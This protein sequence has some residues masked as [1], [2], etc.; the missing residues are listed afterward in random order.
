MET[1]K[2]SNEGQILIPKVLR[3]IC[4]ISPGAELMI[5]VIGSE[6]RLKPAQPLVAPTT[7]AA[8]RGLL[9]QPGRQPLTDA[10]IRQ[11]IAARLKAQDI[12]TPVCGGTK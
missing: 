5:S 6:I 7:V 4:Q 3:E 8:G 2:V 1:V 9:A 10:D 12:A 11:R